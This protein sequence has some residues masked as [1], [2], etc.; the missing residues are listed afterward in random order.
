MKVL[1]P[2]ITVPINGKNYCVIYNNDYTF[3]I[4]MDDTL[5]FDLEVKDGSDLMIANVIHL[6]KPLLSIVPLEQLFGTYDVIQLLCKIMRKWGE[7]NCKSVILKYTPKESTNADIEEVA[8]HIA[9]ENKK[10]YTKRSKTV[11][12][13]VFIC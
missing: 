9:Q 12:R 7:T 13:E 5:I 11:Y 3:T 4:S 10:P 1:R 6:W 2:S 8:L